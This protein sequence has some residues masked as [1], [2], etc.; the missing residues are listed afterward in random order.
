[1]ASVSFGRLVAIGQYRMH[2]AHSIERETTAAAAD[3]DVPTLRA[4]MGIRRPSAAQVGEVHSPRT[5][6]RGVAA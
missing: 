3:D 2:A 5:A 1:V 6:L 4:A